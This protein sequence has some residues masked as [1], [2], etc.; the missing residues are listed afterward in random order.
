[1]NQLHRDIFSC[2]KAAL[3]EEG[4]SLSASLNVQEILSIAKAHQMIPIVYQGL[5]LSGAD[6][7]DAVEMKKKTLQL[8]MYDQ[9]QLNAFREIVDAFS[10]A[11]IDHMPL[12]GSAIKN[13]YPSSEM[14]LMGDIDILIREEQYGQIRPIMES[15][16]F[17]EVEQS[18]HELI[19]KR[20]PKIVIELHKRLIPSYNDD[21]YEYYKDPWGFA[22]PSAQPYRF[23]MRRE[24]EYLYIFT[25]LTKH[26]RDGGIGIKHIVDLWRYAQRY[27]DMDRDYI[28]EELDKLS[29]R[30]FHE[31][32]VHTADVWFADAAPTPVTEHITER[33]VE[34]GAY[35]IK[36]I[37]NTAFA[38]KESAR[39]QSVGAAK[40]KKILH[41]IFLPYAQMKKKYPVLERVP[42]LLPVM[43]VVRWVSALFGRRDKIRTIAREIDRIDTNVVEGYNS[44]LAMVGLRFDLRDGGQDH[45]N[46]E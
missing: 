25:H 8:T 3:T 14:R 22:Q 2:I 46:K 32:I 42:P 31:N 26:Y 29:L 23:A 44:E 43:W 39:E 17:T 28:G 7:S 24:D 6:L 13:L 40:R 16:G 30:A 9:M 33:I 19:W 34:S 41:Y 11:G 35:G 45:E 20:A 5:F 4:A 27:S 18:D 37:K 38:A 21:Y 1:M 15:L 12:K 36:E 10:A